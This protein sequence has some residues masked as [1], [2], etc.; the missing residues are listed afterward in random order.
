MA[1][2]RDGKKLGRTQRRVLEL[3]AGSQLSVQEVAA[4]IGVSV[5]SAKCALDRLMVRGLVAR[6]ARSRDFLY[7]A[8]C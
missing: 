4:S 1:K 2:S 7:T 6:T 5:D 8:G 3:L